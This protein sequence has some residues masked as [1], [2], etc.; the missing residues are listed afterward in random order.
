MSP[1]SA[2]EKPHAAWQVETL[3]ESAGLL[4][5]RGEIAEAENIYRQILETA[6]YHVKALNFLGMQAFKRGENAE[7]VRY[8]EQAVRAAP[9]RAPLHQNLGLV[10]KAAG[11]SDQAL[12][13][14]ERATVLDPELR[15]AHLHKG[16]LLESMGRQ[17]ASVA[18]YWQAW[19]QFPARELLD[20]DVIAPP[21]LRKLAAHAAEQLCRVQ[22]DMLER[23]LQPVRARHGDAALARVQAAAE[24]HLG[25]RKP[26]YL[27]PKQ[28][29]SFIYLP[30]VTP[31]AFFERGELQW[32]SNLEA[33]TADIRAEL[34]AML[35]KTE[36]LMP[37]VQ[38]PEGQ[39]PME[40][41]ELNRSR[42]WS[43]AHILR[44]GAWVAENR[45]RCPHTAAALASLPLPYIAD[46]A[47]EALYSVLQP[48]THIPP[49][50][51]LGNYKLVA[52]LPL[53]VPDSC[54]IRVGDETRGWREGE[55][56]VFDDSFEHEAWNR[57]GSVR[58]VLILDVWNPLVTDA[59]RDGIIAMV[60]A[61]A[62]FRRSYC[63]PG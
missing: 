34:R 24:I 4:A 19:R 7:S 11:A 61:L 48:G 26:A 22:I 50:H 39:D 32:L 23:A 31:R 16:A 20:T 36:D 27:H 30:G 14:L 35:E 25:L 10:H 43:S 56:L 9:D 46:H 13:A 63:G 55:C 53:I 17:D 52:H 37:Y 33:A 42:Q 58:A 28:R 49:H 21:H 54:A 2:G 8:L 5:Q 41:R 45:A 18:A 47:P 40:W 57:S 38:I 1:Q 15:T 29:P 60:N 59:E 12:A 62:A 6:P 51:G 44:S 3:S